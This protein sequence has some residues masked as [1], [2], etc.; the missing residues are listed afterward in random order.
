MLD[1]TRWYQENAREAAKQYEAVAVEAVHGWLE[2][3]LPEN[4]GRALDIGAGSGR[5]AAWLAGFGHKVV[6]VEPS[7]EMRKEAKRWHPRADIQW[8]S[9]SLPSLR[10]LSKQKPFDLILI[11]GVWQHVA[12][13][14]RKRAFRKVINLLKP[15]GVLAISLRHG[16]EVPGKKVHAVSVEEIES[17]ARD[18]GAF[19]AY[20]NE[21][22]DSLGREEVC[23][24]NLVI[25]FPDDGTGAL[26][27][28]RHVILEQSKSATHKL[29]LLR[30]LCR[31]ADGAPGI[32]R[33][34]GDGTVRLPMG[35]VALTWLRL[36][37][38]L[39]QQGLPQTPVSS[40]DRPNL[41]FVKD[42]YRKIEPMLS[43]L[44]L[45]VGEHFDEE[46][47]PDLHQALKDAAINIQRMPITYMTYPG[48]PG[49]QILKANPC[50]PRR[51][52]GGITLDEDYL[53]S[54]GEVR[55]AEDLW[56]ALRKHSVWVEPVVIS[57]WSK[58]IREYAEKKNKSI[59][60]TKLR[61]AMI[62]SDPERDVQISQNQAQRLL[63]ERRLYC[64]WSGKR[65]R[66]KSVDI[67][68]CLPWSVW[69]CGDLWNLMPAHSDVNRNKKRNLLPSES[70]MDEA[71]DR[72]LD[73]WDRAYF[74]GESLQEKFLVEATSSL[75]GVP[76]DTHSLE[77]IFESLCL[78]R[79]KLRRDQ[80]APEWD[81]L[82]AGP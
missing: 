60:E 28:L 5:D 12:K 2:R 11:N 20:R 72:I 54:F 42:A 16:P 76:S 31:I 64:V 35:L 39:L 43:H 24:T 4:P 77:E 30:T 38:P 51:R 25:R 7:S 62:W 71:H 37:K 34:A 82:G 56:Q 78:Q 9:D 58:M 26:P 19:V 23:W 46:H 41:G 15:D 40:P 80:R 18:H 63:E 17:L 13:S 6:A 32:A 70:A 73:W 81:G 50:R 65:L 3:F 49:K 8:R 68:H 74:W 59:D 27:L 44:D 14:D 57:E 75:P 67:D 10:R 61:S 79:A 29:G 48:D 47:G 55:I 52:K 33:H 21:V 36:Y 69:S 22:E 1:S 45:R 53:Y 66:R